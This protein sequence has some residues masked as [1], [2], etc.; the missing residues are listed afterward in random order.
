MRTHTFIFFLRTLYPHITYIT[1]PHTHHSCTRTLM[2]FH[3]TLQK[4]ALEKAQV[5]DKS[6]I[7]ERAGERERERERERVRAH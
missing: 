7:D 3:H 5:A 2:F 4:R 6:K 1:C